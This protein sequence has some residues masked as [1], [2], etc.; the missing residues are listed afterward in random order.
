MAG[1]GITLTSRL[2]EEAGETSTLIWPSA[3]L[4]TAASAGCV[5]CRGG[6]GHQ[7]QLLQRRARAREDHR[8]DL[9]LHAV[10]RG[11]QGVRSRGGAA[12]AACMRPTRAHKLVGSVVMQVLGMVADVGPQLSARQ[13]AR[14]HCFS[15]HACSPV[16]PRMTPHTPCRWLTSRMWTCPRLAPPSLAAS[17]W[18]WWTT[19]PS[20]LPPSRQVALLLGA[21]AAASGE[22]CHR[23]AALHCAMLLDHGQGALQKRTPKSA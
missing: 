8:Q 20:T 9:R 18:R 11:A 17:R 13:G 4:L 21:W 12:G 16:S 2:Q 10:D 3:V 1:S 7:V 6:L 22:L 15:L 19:P 23:A 14:M 5:A